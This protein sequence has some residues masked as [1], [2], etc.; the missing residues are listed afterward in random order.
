MCNI[1]C[2]LTNELHQKVVLVYDPPSIEGHL[3]HEIYMYTYPPAFI[4]QRWILY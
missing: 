3:Q 4:K 1:W 2:K